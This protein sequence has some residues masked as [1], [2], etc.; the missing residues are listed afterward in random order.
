MARSPSASRR[1][2]PSAIQYQIDCNCG[3][4]SLLQVDFESG[5]ELVHGTARFPPDDQFHCPTCKQLFDLAGIREL[6]EQNMGRTVI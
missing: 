4:K 5:T 3:T 6:I 2:G 1:A